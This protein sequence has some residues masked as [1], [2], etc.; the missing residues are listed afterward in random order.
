MPRAFKL[1]WHQKNEIRQQR[2]QAGGVP[3]TVADEPVPLLEVSLPL[4]SYQG[5]P[6]ST[7]AILKQRVVATL[8][9]PPG[10]YSI[11]LSVALVDF[12]YPH[13]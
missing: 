6:A 4:A 5:A 10:G 2:A 12:V 11:L 13:C 8:T 9:L 1:G 7:I 3:L